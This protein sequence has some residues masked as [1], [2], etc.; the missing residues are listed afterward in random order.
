M[1]KLFAALA[2]VTVIV[3]MAGA[4]QAS[5]NP[6]V[7]NSVP[8][9]LPGNAPSVGFQAT[10]TGQFG[11]AIKLAPGKRILKSV[12]VVMSSWACGS[13]QWN[14]GTCHTTPGTTFTEPITLNIYALGVNGSVG[15]R[16]VHKTQTF[17]I[18]FRPS[19]NATKCPGMPCDRVVLEGG[20]EVLQ[21][22]GPEHLVHV[23]PPEHQAAQPVHLRHRVQHERL[24]CSP[25]RLLDRV[26]PGCRDGMPV[27]R[28]E[29]RSGGR[30][31]DT[32]AGPVPG[33]RLPGQH[34]RC[35][36]LRHRHRRDGYVP[37]RRRLLD[38]Y[39]PARSDPRQEVEARRRR[40]RAGR[41]A[42]HLRFAAHTGS[43]G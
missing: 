39:E 40:W 28:A 42:L 31:A 29:R 19:T 3:A 18:Q 9:Q 14:L 37:P 30:S 34:H 26:R 8:D 43:L 24:R 16:I 11:D 4:A 20:Q 12:R 1:R 7:F 2:A 6:I 41:P 22:A 10:Q 23:Q 13:G 15:P 38:G 25:V 17:T 35:E 36:L 32:R 5:P 21:R 27:R 33:W